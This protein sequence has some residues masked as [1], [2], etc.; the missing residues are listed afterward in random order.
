VIIVP[1]A[2][3]TQLQYYGRPSMGWTKLRDVS[4]SAS[5]YEDWK[6]ILPSQPEV[7]LAKRL[8]VYG[9]Y[10]VVEVKIGTGTWTNVGSVDLPD[11]SMINVTLSH[12]SGAE[13]IDNT[14]YI[15]RRSN[16]VTRPGDVRLSLFRLLFPTVN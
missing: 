5:P 9:L 4:L 13:I 8:F 14:L 6:G 11:G 10:K 16:D 2:N 3:P 7:N 12:I 15:S 1:R